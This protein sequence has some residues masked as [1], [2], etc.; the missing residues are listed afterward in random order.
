MDVHSHHPGSSLPTMFF[1][2][3]NITV[4]VCWG[5]DTNVIGS[6][7]VTEIKT[8][9]HDEGKSLNSDNFTI[10][11]PATSRP[12]PTTAKK[13]SGPSYTFDWKE[14]PRTPLLSDPHNRTGHTKAY[15]W[16]SCVRHPV[17]SP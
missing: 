7:N 15:A 1:G 2:P 3:S 4:K 14:P 5:T 11:W 6:E 8:K 9:L 12:S 17:S 10:I 13:Q 16:E